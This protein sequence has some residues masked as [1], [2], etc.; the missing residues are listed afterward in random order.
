MDDRD[1]AELWVGV[2]RACEIINEF[3]LAAALSCGTLAKL[4]ERNS[5]HTSDTEENGLSAIHL[6]TLLAALNGE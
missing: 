4:Y 1:S 5:R 3:S 2:E 6:S